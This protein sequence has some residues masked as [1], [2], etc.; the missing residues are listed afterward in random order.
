M[1]PC[2]A[3]RP[4]FLCSTPHHLL[5]HL[6][7]SCVNS[8]SVFLFPS[9]HNPGIS[10][11]FWIFSPFACW[12][13]STKLRIHSLLWLLLSEQSWPATVCW[14]DP[15]H[16][17]VQLLNAHIISSTSHQILISVKKLRSGK[18]LKFSKRTNQGHFWLVCLHFESRLFRVV[19]ISP[20]C[21]SLIVWIFYLLRMVRFIKSLALLREVRATTHHAV[22]SHTSMTL[23]PVIA[24]ATTLSAPSQAAWGIWCSGCS[25]NRYY[26]LLAKCYVS[27][28]PKQLDSETVLPG[29]RCADCWTLTKGFTHL[30]SMWPAVSNAPSKTLCAG[31]YAKIYT[32]LQTTMG[33]VE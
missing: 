3:P 14:F 11:Q 25:H 2:R 28:Q 33:A 5:D 15:V 20:L 17:I 12:V 26:S 6:S 7:V 21:K 10:F 23:P 32:D 24:P 18:S 8:F 27:K 16:C 9:S 13:Y 19:R 29:D 22:C 4:H 1:C 30:S 31:F